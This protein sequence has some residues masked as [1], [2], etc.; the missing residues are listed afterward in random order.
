MAHFYYG[1]LKTAEEQIDMG[2]AYKLFLVKVFPL[3]VMLYN[4]FLC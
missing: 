3:Y 4:V 2:K 1:M